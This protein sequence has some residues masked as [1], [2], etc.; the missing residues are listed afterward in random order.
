MRKLIAVLSLVS[1]SSTVMAKEKCVTYDLL[2]EQEKLKNTEGLTADTL[3]FL[4]QGTYNVK[5]VQLLTCIGMN[6]K[7]SKADSA[8]GVAF[9]EDDLKARLHKLEQDRI[10]YENLLK[11]SELNGIE[12]EIYSQSLA[13]IPHQIEQEKRSN[14]SILRGLK[15]LT[16]DF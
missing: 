1:I 14:A 6:K 5:M 3:P 13:T 4:M 2:A 12:R 16:R 15:R 10:N 7:I 11:D 8:F 9:M